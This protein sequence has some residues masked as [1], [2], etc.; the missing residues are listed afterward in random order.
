MQGALDRAEALRLAVEA[1]L[2]L[3][4]MQ[5]TTVS[6]A[7]AAESVLTA[8]TSQGDLVLRHVLAV[9]PRTLARMDHYERVNAVAFSPEGTLVVTGS[10]NGIRGGSTRTYER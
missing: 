8:S 4:T 7:L 2:A 10:G 6:L 1:E 9:H 5:A 3:R